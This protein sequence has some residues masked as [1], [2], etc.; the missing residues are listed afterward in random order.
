MLKLH[1]YQ[2]GNVA[3]MGGASYDADAQLWFDA[4]VTAGGSVSDAR[5]VIVNTLVA[6]LKTDSLWTLLD[7]LWLF[8]AE[9]A[10]AALID[11][12]GLSTATAVNTPTFTADQGYAGNGTTSYINTNYAP[13]THGVQYVQ[14]SAH[15]SLYNRTSR[16]TTSGF[17]AQ[18]G[19]HGASN[20]GTSYMAIRPPT[21]TE[22]GIN[23]VPAW[24]YSG[25]PNALG[26]YVATRTGAGTTDGALY[27]NGSVITKTGTIASNGTTTR[28]IYVLQSNSFGGYSTDQIAA[29]GAG[30]ALDATQAG[31]LSSRVN[32]YMTSLG[33]NVY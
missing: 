18:I 15:L 19:A 2:V 27:R 3:A 26:M 6:G 31:N 11:I 8:A 10:T 23:M 14:N 22:F 4:V 7:R 32:A 16:T 25:P 29:A 30:G 24:G 12:K 17:P 1:P 33:T 20:V 21:S 13:G 9:N 28:N 5:K